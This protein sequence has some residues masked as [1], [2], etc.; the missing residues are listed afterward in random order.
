MSGFWNDM[1][2]LEIGNG[3]F[4]CSTPQSINRTKAHF[5]IWSVM[6]A[7]LLLGTDRTFTANPE[8]EKT[9]LDIVCN[10]LVIGVNQDP[11]SVQARR[12]SSVPGPAVAAGMV[13]NADVTFTVHACDAKRPTQRWRHTLNASSAMDERFHR[14]AV[15]RHNFGRRPCGTSRPTAST[16]RPSAKARTG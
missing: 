5:S 7:P 1:E 14:P 9:I 13:T 8:L 16:N 2:F 10:S 12:V 6:K 3:E 15:V 4:D 11:L